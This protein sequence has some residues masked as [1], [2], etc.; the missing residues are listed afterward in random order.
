[1]LRPDAARHA[2][3]SA[4]HSLLSVR[5][6]DSSDRKEQPLPT[7]GRWFN[8][9]AVQKALGHAETQWKRVAVKDYPNGAL[10]FC[11]ESF[12][13]LVHAPIALRYRIYN[14]H[15]HFDTSFLEQSMKTFCAP[16]Y[17][18]VVVD[19][20]GATFGIAQGLTAVPSMVGHTKAV[21][22][23][24]TRR[25]GQSA[26]R[27][28][29][30]HEESSQAFLRQ[31]AE[32]MGK[33]FDHVHKIIVAGK[34][35]MKR[36]LL[37]ELPQAMRAKVLCVV[38]ISG[39]ANSDGL[40]QAMLCARNLDAV[41]ADEFSEVEQAVTEFIDLTTMSLEMCCYGASMTAAAIEMGAV[42]KLLVSTAND[43]N[44]GSDHRS[45]EDWKALA[46]LC[47][48][49]VI[50]VEPRSTQATHFCTNYGI[51][52]CLRWPVDLGSLD[53]PA[54]ADEPSDER[55]PSVH[56]GVLDVPAFALEISDTPESS[57]PIAKEITI[58][59][60]CASKT[61]PQ[62]EGKEDLKQPLEREESPRKYAQR[63]A[64]SGLLEWLEGK[65]VAA[66]NDE[67]VVEGLMSWAEV[68]LADNS[69]TE[70]GDDW[71][72]PLA[73]LKLLLHDE[74]V[75]EEVVRQLASRCASARF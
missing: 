33:S 11:S 5:V 57:E 67:C 19:G 15:N 53:E 62:A 73:Q 35:D 23:S 9:K 64:I 72:S 58:E 47:G 50:E 66:I 14:C 36:H 10:V 32:K 25:G 46:K 20:S 56:D 29:H 1:M 68:L 42:S 45:I 16:A 37:P 61:G 65:L 40:R 39:D 54:S 48:A 75:P 55:H 8:R 63:T 3:H 22:S 26:K 31:V 60:T 6:P 49:Q 13:E 70:D 69:T 51:G 71:E 44:H 2:S 74:G 27:F 24:N 59:C 7:S 18:I 38:D 52:A 21:I 34:A 28:A 41:K 43:S 17:G 4:C 30:L 12:A